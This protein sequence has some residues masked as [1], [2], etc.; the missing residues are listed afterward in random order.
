MKKFRILGIISILVVI[1][2]IIGSF[3]DFKRGAEEGWNHADQVRSDS[4]AENSDKV[5][6]ARVEVRQLENTDEQKVG[7]S[8]LNKDVPYEINTITTYV[9]SS[10]WH[11]ILQMLTLPWAFAFLYGF[12]CLIRFLIAISKREVFTDKNVHRIRWFAYSFVGGE[13]LMTLLF[14]LKEQA[15]VAQISLPGYEVVSNVLIEAD[16]I[17]MIIIILFAEIFA[18][19][20]KIKEEQDLTI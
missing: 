9:E 17:S 19:G 8:Q 4:I 18:V 1:T 13:F 14:W 10:T 3:G 12:Y 20:T 5:T 11:N 2:H 15:A 7:N 16:W 6:Y